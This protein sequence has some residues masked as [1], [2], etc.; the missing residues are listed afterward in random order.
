MSH[1]FDIA[2]EP[3]AL[4]EAPERTHRLDIVITPIDAF[5]EETIFGVEAHIDRQSK[6]AYRS[7][8]G[9]LVFER[10]LPRDR[11][12]VAFDTRGTGY[13]EPPPREIAM[14]QVKVL[15]RQTFPDNAARL[16][17][18][19]ADTRILR[20]FRRPDAV[21]DGEA[22]IVRGGVIKDGAPAGGVSVTGTVVGQ[23]NVT[24]ETLT[25]ELGAFAIR[26][27]LPAP[28]LDADAVAVPQTARVRLLFDGAHEWRSETDPDLA[29]VQGRLE[30]MRTHII[31]API[32]IG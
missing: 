16:A 31:G 17:A 20:L 12:L 10:L 19:A 27:R 18:L 3:R 13:F 22:L 14:P 1:S 11:H 28:P 9:H 8:S 2:F 24:F 21:V 32:D 7:L 23:P 25:N 30:D 5:T 4:R 6:K 26:L 29:A 15:P